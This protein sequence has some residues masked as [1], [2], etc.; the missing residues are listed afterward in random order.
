MAILYS[1]TRTG[2][3]YYSANNNPVTMYVYLVECHLLMS[4]L[5]IY[6]CQQCIYVLIKIE[7]IFISFALESS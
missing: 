4:S 7:G 6:V 5:D 2:I 3:E 1:H